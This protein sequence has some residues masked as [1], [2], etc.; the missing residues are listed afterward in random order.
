MRLAHRA[1]IAALVSLVLCAA[2]SAQALRSPNDPR[3]QSPSV[4]TG[5]PEGGP[6]GLFTIYD[7]STLRRGEFTF[8]IAYSNYDR[9]PGNVDIVEVPLS[10]NVGLNDHIELFFKTNGYRGIK[11]NNPQNLSSFYLPNSQLF[12]GTTLCSPPAIVLAPSGPNVGTLAN[13]AV[14]RP[15]NNQPFVQFPF[16][17]GSAG[18]FGQGPGQIG[19]QFGFPGFN[20]LLGPPVA[21]PNSGTF[22]TAD[23]FPGIGS[24]VGG[25]LPGVVLA[26]TT[27]PATALT[28]PITVPLTFTV[29]PSYLP[30][31]PFI[32]RLYGESNFTNMV[33]GAK[34]RFTGPNN[35]LGVAVIPMYR[36]WL[37]KG[38]DFSGYNQ[39]Q[40]GAGPGGD[41]GDFGIMGVVD[42]RLGKHVNVS[43]NGGYWLN[44]N[45][46]GLGDF[47][48]LDRPDE[49][50]AGVGFDF[51]VNEHFQPIAE[52][53]ST[54]YVGG[55]TPNAF[56]NNPVDVL[57]GIKIYPR[58]WFGIGIAYRRH[59]N[60]QDQD[61]FNPA[62]F[63]IPIQ[64][65][66]NVNVI[67]R[68]PPLVV[69]PGTSRPVT[70]QGFPLGFVFSDEPNGFI[71]QFWAGRRNARIPPRMNQPPIVTSVS[72]SISTITR[73]C[74]PEQGTSSTCP[75]TNEVTLTALASDPDNDQLLYTWS[76]TGG[77]LSGE[78]R[79]VKWDLTGV[80][81]GTYN[82][83]VEVNDG[84]QHTANGSATV[85][86]TD[87]TD[88]VKPPPPCPTVSVSCPSEVDAGQ[89]ITFTASLAGETGG[90]T[91]TYNW[92]VS[93]GTISSGQGTST[94][95]V[96]TNGV[97]TSV[98]ATVSVGG[99]DPSCN[100][101]S[102]CTTGVK[103]T[104]QPPRK[105][106][107]YGNI[108]FNDEKARLDNYA[109]QL[110]NEPGSTATIIVY[111]T[112]AGEGQQRG[113]RAKDY[114]VNTRGIEAG[115]IT[116]VDGGCSS[117]L[118]V[119]LWIVPSGSDA[120]EVDTSG[121]IS[122]CPECRRKGGRRR[123]GRRGDEE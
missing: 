17:G 35:P 90:A 34:I 5:G 8:S 101:T 89:S 114:L 81:N 104:K 61:H 78:G 115:R 23:N 87:C 64:Q 109:I 100:A 24:P 71:F 91:P 1:L 73:A 40:R 74:P 2:V 117:E 12:C 85:T 14:F 60:Q 39:M 50:L 62:D 110:Q 112:C 66:T 3:N 42:G 92:S 21:Q 38:N 69:V 28:L 99:L 57:G 72:T 19:Q 43:A 16:V 6:T 58:R 97:A 86:V 53:R 29:A 88:C 44:S 82:A 7:G 52:V 70:S 121:V 105:F 123:P 11:V 26:T 107:E 48:L 36:W 83:T 41:I 46:K 65:L 102:S 103:P 25:I 27:L 31:A 30:D 22:G 18:T 80:A 120:P 68:V 113:D 77:R 59:L 84:N 93:A 51:P 118:K 15:L 116:V 10:F 111:G 37:D 96:D 108:R 55:R 4:G 32:N 33:F 9:D 45:P 122:P 75:S 98:T 106:D 63:T 67:G 95:T 119:Q 79:E 49:L 20:A 56:E 13:T 47:V 94:I 76:V 54:T